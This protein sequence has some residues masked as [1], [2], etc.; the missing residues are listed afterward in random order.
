M[1]I[2]KMVILHLLGHLLAKVELEGVVVEES[3]VGQ[4]E[5]TETMVAYTLKRMTPI[6]I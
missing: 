4:K 1:E 2:M 5:G 3:V 6:L